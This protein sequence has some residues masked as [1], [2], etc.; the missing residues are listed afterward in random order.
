MISKKQNT[1]SGGSGCGCSAVV[2]EA[3]V[4]KRMRSGEIKRVS[5][6]SNRS[7]AFSGEL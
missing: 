3:Y 6:C 2:L 1:M 5:F 4:L 7:I